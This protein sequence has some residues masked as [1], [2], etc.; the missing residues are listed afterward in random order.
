MCFEMGKLIINSLISFITLKNRFQCLNMRENT[1]IL[2]RAKER[3][4]S[5][6]LIS[7]PMLSEVFFGFALFPFSNI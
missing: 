2:F 5:L 6:L 4:H 1:K 3:K 7:S